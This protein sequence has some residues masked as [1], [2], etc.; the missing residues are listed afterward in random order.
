[1]HPGRI[2]HTKVSSDSF[3]QADL[4]PSI[5]HISVDIE[6]GS[7]GIVVLVM[8]TTLRARLFGFSRDLASTI[9]HDFVFSLIFLL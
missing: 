3:D 9:D 8:R 4:Q 5:K 7:C 2:S 6:Y 1:M